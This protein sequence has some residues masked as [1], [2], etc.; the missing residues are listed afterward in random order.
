MATPIFS[1]YVGNYSSKFRD[2]PDDH[3]FQSSWA[4]VPQVAFDS[5]SYTTRDQVLGTPRRPIWQEAEERFLQEKALKR[6]AFEKELGLQVDLDRSHYLAL[7]SVAV[8]WSVVSNIAGAFGTGL[9]Y[10]GKAIHAVSNG[11]GKARGFVDSRRIRDSHNPMGRRHRRRGR[12]QSSDSETESESG[13]GTQSMLSMPPHM[14]G[15][16]P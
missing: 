6:V 16:T 8:V 15:A 10:A 5:S 12:V 11:V 3:G 4:S 13:N 7:S 2:S 14:V 9:G 1:G